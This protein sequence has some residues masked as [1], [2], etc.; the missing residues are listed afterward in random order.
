MGI[1]RYKILHSVRNGHIKRIT[2]LD[3]ELPVF[4]ISGN[5]IINNY[6]AYPAGK[7][8]SMKIRMPIL[9]LLVKNVELI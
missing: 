2:D 5:N 7:N 9:V 6:L 3:I 8:A 1:K 4:E